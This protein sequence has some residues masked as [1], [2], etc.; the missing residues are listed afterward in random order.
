MRRF[1]CAV[2]LAVAG[3]LTAP[4]AAAQQARVPP[5]VPQP[6]VRP[7]LL[8][9]PV[10]NDPHDSI[11]T[12]LARDLDFGDVLL[13]RHYEVELLRQ[14]VEGESPPILHPDSVTQFG[15]RFVVKAERRLDSLRVTVFDTTLRTAPVTRSYMVRPVPQ[16]LARLVHDSVVAAFAARETSG[17]QQL[18]RLR[19]V[20]DSLLQA[21]RGRQPRNPE[22]RAL[23][24]V[25]RDSLFRANAAE[26]AVLHEQISRFPSERDSLLG[27]LV[28]RQH[29]RYDSLVYLQ[30]M[31]VHTAADELQQWLGGV[32]G[33]A[34]SRIAFVRGGLLHVV[35]ADGAN[36]QQLTVRGRALSPAWH[37]SG[38]WITYSDITDVGTQVAEVDVGTG[39][40]RLLTSTPRGYNITPVYTPDGKQLVFATSAS[41]GSQLVS[42]DRETLKMTRLSAQTRNASSPTF[43]PDG[44]RIAFVMPRTWQGSGS[45]VRMTPQLFTATATGTGI[46]QLTPSTFGVRSYRTSPE[47]SPDG[48]FVTYTQQGGGFQVWLIGLNDRR[49]RQLTSGRDHEDASW[50]PDSRHLVITAG[51]DETELVVL[52]IVTGRRRPVVADGRL[53]AWG[54]RWDPSQPLVRGGSTIATND[55]N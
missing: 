41:G 29:A 47:W 25:R 45:T 19:A 33:S 37:P 2:L 52:D 21:S 44:R 28:A 48:R 8:L 9:L 55:D 17:R 13:V 51:R 6:T 46:Q 30:R 31:D 54:P 10:V 3:S 36:E 20:Y 35:D 5:A 39:E 42:V 27:V 7:S 15:T 11:R 4:S 16:N 40:V 26:A 43:S 18:V 12:I 38:R 24:V 23:A 34:A 49:S 53:P 50:A 1:H 22:Q 14:L 32:R